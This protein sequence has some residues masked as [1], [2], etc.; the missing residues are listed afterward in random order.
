[1]TDLT[2]ALDHVLAMQQAGEHLEAY[3]S[4]RRI[5]TVQAGTGGAIR[6][7]D[8]SETLGIGLRLVRDHR[9]GYASTAD[10][11]RS[12]LVR[13]V[14]QARTHAALAQAN[15][16]SDL[17]A[18]G[19]TYSGPATHWGSTALAPSTTPASL[20]EQLVTVVSLARQAFSSHRSVRVIDGA[21]YRDEQCAV[22]IG[23]TT[24][25]RVAHERSFI[26]AW[27][28]VIGDDGSVTATGSGYW[29]GRAHADV[30]PEVIA[31]DAVGQ[32]VRLLG[33][34]AD[35]ISGA[36]IVLR[37]DVAAAF[38][39]AAGRALTAPLV[40]SGRGPLA[41]G[42]GAAVASSVVTL[43]DDGHHPSSKRAAPFDDEGVARHA[44]S[45]IT[46]GAVSGMLSS[47]GTVRGAEH[48]T[49]NASRGS[50]K[51]PPEVAPTTLVLAPTSAHGEVMLG[52]VVVIEQL[53]G[54][55][56]GISSVTGRIDLAV[57]GYVLRDA[58]PAGAF[59]AV[60]V[61][62]T[63]RDLL[64]A[65][66]AVADDARVVNRSPALAPTVRLVPGLFG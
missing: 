31:R 6:Q 63:L 43:T 10:L 37:P 1:M 36:P 35:A 61:S 60:P 18:I 20:R 62:T 26:E 58:E 25:L 65:I 5:T 57:T 50:H 24:G 23:A 29:W 48:S 54:E 47:T 7:V 66:D 32:A 45:L 17:P 42:L 34:R 22:E 28:D 30:D 38:I 15:P 21:A 33:R 3:G 8:Q 55:R 46:G 27:V 9:T 12:G 64:G 19:T 11:S 44:T 56:S 2:R 53:S 16:A 4:H 40:R 14:D 51:S 52:D 39:A 59:A 13:C 41:A 49:G